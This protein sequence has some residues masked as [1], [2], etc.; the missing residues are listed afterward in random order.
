MPSNSVLVSA[1]GSGK[2]TKIVKAAIAN[3]NQRALLTT[4]T[5]NNTEEIRKKVIESAGYVPPNLRIMPWFTFLLDELVRP[6]QNF[7]YDRRRIE[8][9]SMVEGR[10]AKGI[11]RKNTTKYYLSNGKDIY[12][13]KISDFICQID[14]ISDGLVHQRLS[15]IYDAIYLD[16]V[17]DLA[18]WDLV[19]LE[20]LL[21][22]PIELSLV[23][24]YRQATFKTNQS[25]K[26][27]QYSGA[28]IITLFEEWER[29]G[30]CVLTSNQ[31]S[32]R[33]NQKICDFADRFFPAAP[34]TVSKNNKVTGH[35]GVFF[36]TSEDVEKYQ[37]TYNPQ[38]LRFNVRTDC[39]GFPAL[40]FGD[41]KGLTFNRV[42][43]FPHGPFKEALKTGDFTELK[44]L[45]KL[46][47]GAT[48]ARFSVA[49][50]FDQQSP[51]P[52]QKYTP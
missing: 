20:S 22:T 32:Y 26:Y 44:S 30:R 50:V 5:L 3:P 27:S 17:Q 9:I 6:Y 41:A 46:Y 31:E 21:D 13:D 34:N 7:L 38:I 52:I 19:V 49:I 39:A 14:D 4:Y 16:E 35:D 29:A 47:V 12:T 25:G 18:G 2:T 24:D 37:A 43:I 11:P 8:A 40:N 48:R 45:E 28:N 36:V 10:S 1:A 15:E 42:M 51:L 23:G 33:C